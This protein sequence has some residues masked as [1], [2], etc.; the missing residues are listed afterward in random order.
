MF[1]A[2]GAISGAIVAAIAAALVIGPSDV[3]PVAAVVGA[4]IGALPAQT[5]ISRPQ[6]PSAAFL[7]S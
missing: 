3:M 2:A 5:A 7:C 4:A 6:Q 1:L